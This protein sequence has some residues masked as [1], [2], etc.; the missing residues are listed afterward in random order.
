MLRQAGLQVIGDPDV[1]MIGIETFKDVDV[2][3]FVSPAGRIHEQI[4]ETRI[5]L[6]RPAVALR[7]MAGQPSLTSL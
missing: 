3:H 2:F 1:E 4:I 6:P 7:A 5:D